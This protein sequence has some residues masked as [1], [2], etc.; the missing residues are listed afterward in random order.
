MALKIGG[1]HSGLGLKKRI[2]GQIKC[3]ASVQKNSGLEAILCVCEDTTTAL[4]CKSFPLNSASF[5]GF[6]VSNMAIFHAWTTTKASPD[7]IEMRLIHCLKK[8]V[9]N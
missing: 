9:K 3:S 2:V 6:L 8:A 5:S 1:K 7:E 4:N